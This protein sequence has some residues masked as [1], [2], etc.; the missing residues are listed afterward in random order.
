MSTTRIINTT[1]G[2]TDLLAVRSIDTE[3]IQAGVGQP[4]RFAFTID[5]G[6]SRQ[7]SRLFMTT[8]TIDS[9][10]ATPLGF[11]PDGKISTTI[12][13][14]TGELERYNFHCYN[15]TTDGRIVK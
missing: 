8:D 4:E 3:T 5:T 14:T 13:T 12:S 11:R 2:A 9:T 6:P 1:T 10:P 7:V 15:Y